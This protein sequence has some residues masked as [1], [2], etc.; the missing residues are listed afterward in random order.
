L[1]STPGVQPAAVS[2]PA[3]FLSKQ[4]QQQET[5][6]IFNAN[7]CEGEA[8]KCKLDFLCRYFHFTLQQALEV[9]TNQSSQQG[10]N[11]DNECEF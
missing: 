4:Q 11:S 2:Q 9:S 5:T 10:I 3:I 1:V 7:S 8:S 6:S